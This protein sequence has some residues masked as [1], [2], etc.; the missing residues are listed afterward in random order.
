MYMFSVFSGVHPCSVS[1]FVLN[2]AR[3]S[4]A[5]FWLHIRY[6]GLY[7]NVYKNSSELCRSDAIG[8]SRCFMLMV[9]ILAQ[10]AHY[11]VFY[12]PFGVGT[13]VPIFIL[14]YTETC[15]NI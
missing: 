5:P 13:P 2:G 10:S 11:E 12:M 4:S 8:N 7:R 15:P 1:D 14:N 9:P 3:T 6:I